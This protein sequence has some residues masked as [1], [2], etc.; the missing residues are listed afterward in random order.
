[1]IGLIL[2]LAIAV[3]MIASMWKIFSKAGQP[4]WAAI[5]PIYNYIVL[6]KIAEKPA[7]WGILALLPY[8][9]AIFGIWLWNRTVIRFGKSVG[10]TIGSIL[11]P[12]I[13]I[14]MLAFGSAT[15]TPQGDGEGGAAAGGNAEGGSA[16]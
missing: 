14:P 16:E 15:Y 9:G 8:V 2:M 10:F 12:I 7:W 13:F 3:F 5:V 4:G 6:A 1:M 11:L